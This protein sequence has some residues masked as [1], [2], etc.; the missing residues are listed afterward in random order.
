[1]DKV[2]ELMSA[3]DQWIDAK[4]SDAIALNDKDGF[5]SCLGMSSYSY[6]NEV[7]KIL[8]LVFDEKKG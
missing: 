4:I 2:T 8:H 7:E 1:M 5:D 6:R 3:L